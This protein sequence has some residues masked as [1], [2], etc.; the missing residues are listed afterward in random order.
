MSEEIFDIIGESAEA[1]GEGAAGVGKGIVEGAATLIGPA[2]IIGI[3]AV[4]FH[5]IAKGFR[6]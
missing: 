5:T 4:D 3:V 6:K 2:A 1:A